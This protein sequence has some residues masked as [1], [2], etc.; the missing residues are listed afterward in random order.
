M[1][2]SPH[3]PPTEVPQANISHHYGMAVTPKEHWSTAMSKPPHFLWVSPVFPFALF[4][5]WEPIRDIVSRRH[6]S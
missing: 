5:P 4:L 1:N 3:T 6:A 2:T